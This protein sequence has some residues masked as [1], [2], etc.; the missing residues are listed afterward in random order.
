M[1]VYTKGLYINVQKQR[2]NILLICTNSSQTSVC[3]GIIWEDFFVK[4]Y[5]VGLYLSFWIS[6]TVMCQKI[7]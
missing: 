1:A 4:V 7:L 2:D 6:K 3:I 5:I